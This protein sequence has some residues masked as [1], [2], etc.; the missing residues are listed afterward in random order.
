M[1]KNIDKVKWK[2]VKTSP[3]MTTYQKFIIGILSNA[4]QQPDFAQ[5]AEIQKLVDACIL[6]SNNGIPVKIK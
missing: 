5:G 2:V 1:G 4:P 3:T 6:S